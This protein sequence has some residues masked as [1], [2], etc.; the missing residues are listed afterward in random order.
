MATRDQEIT[1]SDNAGTAPSGSDGGSDQ[2]QLA[3]AAAAS[4]S[5]GQNVVTITPPPA[6][7]RVEIKV[8][9]GQKIHTG[10]PVGLVEVM[11]TFNQILYEGA[12]RPEEAEATGKAK[13]PIDGTTRWSVFVRGQ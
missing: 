7:E 3:Q 4:A 5:A 8:E 10:Q 1:P 13:V 11:K 12:G 2:I 9:A 6:G